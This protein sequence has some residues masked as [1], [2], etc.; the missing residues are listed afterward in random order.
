MDQLSQQSD[1]DCYLDAITKNQNRPCDFLDD[2][3]KTFLNIQF[4]RKIEFLRTTLAQ[5]KSSENQKGYLFVIDNTKFPENGANYK[6]PFEIEVLYHLDVHPSNRY[7][8][9]TELRKNKYFLIYILFKVGISFG[10]IFVF[11]M[12]LLI[13]CGIKCKKHKKKFEELTE[14]KVKGF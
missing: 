5:I 7:Y 11:S 2:S 4:N 12:G 1:F 9:T 3:E 6:N 8:L 13:Y 14:E 10:I